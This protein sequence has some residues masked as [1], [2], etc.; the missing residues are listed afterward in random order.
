[1]KNKINQKFNDLYVDSCE[2]RAFVEKMNKYSTDEIIE[3]YG[4]KTDTISYLA[5]IYKKQP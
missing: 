2:F 1:M 4:L 5:A 3:Q